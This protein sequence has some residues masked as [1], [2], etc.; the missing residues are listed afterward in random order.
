MEGKLAEAGDAKADSKTDAKADSDALTVQGPFVPVPSSMTHPLRYL[1][2]TDVGKGPLELLAL[3]GFTL[4]SR[5]FIDSTVKS[6]GQSAPSGP[7]PL[8]KSAREAAKHAAISLPT[9]IVPE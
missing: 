4:P 9:G 3:R 7:P 8:P 5:I 2:R 6:A 1:I